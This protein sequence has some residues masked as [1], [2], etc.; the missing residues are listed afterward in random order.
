MGILK[1]IK[2]RLKLNEETARKFH[3]IEISILSIL[4]FQDLCEV[5]LTLVSKK[6]NIPLVW[7]SIIEDNPISEYIKTIDNSDIVKSKTTFLSIKDFCIVTQIPEKSKANTLLPLLINTNMEKFDQ[8]FPANYSQ[9][10]ASLAIV[11]IILDGKMIGSLNLADS[12]SKRFEPGIDT[13]LLEQLAVKISLCFSNVTA[14]EKLKYLAFHDPLTGL[15]NRGVLDRILKRE[16]ERAKRYNT[17]LSIIFFDLD[18]FKTIND[19]HGHDIGD[20]ILII[21]AKIFENLQRGSDIISRYAGDEFVAILPST[22]LTQAEE[23]VI[24]VKEAFLKKPV[25]AEKGS[26][27]IQASH[28]IASFFE[29]NCKSPF[30]LLKHADT[31]LYLAK[32]NKNNKP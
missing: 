12:D 16:C 2:Q 23:Y 13:S 31:N 22:K 4:N 17:D 8:F 29:D 5:L 19:T 30:K 3:E 28:G 20:R 11:P 9:R 6:F 1:S 24:R 14:H 25:Q 18:D 27:H 26:F 7:F 10:I 15:V 21:T 32:Q